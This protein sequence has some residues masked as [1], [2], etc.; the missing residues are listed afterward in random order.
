VAYPDYRRR[1]A[2]TPA[3]PAPEQPVRPNSCWTSRSAEWR[4]G[5]YAA[6]CRVDQLGRR[7]IGVVRLLRS[8][9][10]ALPQ[11]ADW[12]VA[13][14]NRGSRPCVLV[15]ILAIGREWRQHTYRMV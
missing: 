2:H 6:F 1:H 9:I 12:M 14:P 4:H 8:S 15:D 11:R 5:L 3:S 7:T 13:A 10:P